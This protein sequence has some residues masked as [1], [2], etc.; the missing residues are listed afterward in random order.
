MTDLVPEPDYRDKYLRALAELENLRKRTAKD[1]VAA[2]DQGENR[3]IAEFLPIIDDFQR[4]LEYDA[5]AAVSHAQ[6]R[7]GWQ[8]VFQKLGQVLDRLEVLGVESVGRKF[9]AELMEA[10]TQ[11]SAPALAPGT[12]VAQLEPGYTRRGKLLRAAKV[13]VATQEDP[14]DP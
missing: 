3:A 7:E 1:L 10:V 14:H 9:T 2:R 5:T 8:L 6:A 12:V 11:I 13:A 4:A